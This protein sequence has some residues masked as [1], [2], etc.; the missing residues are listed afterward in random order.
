M[1]CFFKARC[2][3]IGTCHTKQAAY[4]TAENASNATSHFCYCTEK[5][6]AAT[7]CCCNRTDE[8]RE[9]KAS[10]SNCTKNGIHKEY[11]KYYVTIEPTIYNGNCYR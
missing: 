9:A 8:D 7:A 10:V 1:F 6:N 5:A 4:N 11:R 2:R 3:G